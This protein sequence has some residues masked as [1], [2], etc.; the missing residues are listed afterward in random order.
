MVSWIIQF[1]TT[2]RAG[3]RTRFAATF[4]GGRHLPGQKGRLGAFTTGRATAPSSG[5]PAKGGT[6]DGTWWETNET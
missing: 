6:S 5:Q 3:H 1:E 4:P 2:S